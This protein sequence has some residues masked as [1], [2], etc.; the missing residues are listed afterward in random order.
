[1]LFREKYRCFSGGASLKGNDEDFSPE[2]IVG[3]DPGYFK[4]L[5]D[6]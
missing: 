1:M 3:S 2:Q 6:R 4:I 5:Y